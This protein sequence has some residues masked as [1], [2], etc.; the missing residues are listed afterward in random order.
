[1]F[2]QGIAKTLFKE[3][4]DKSPWNHLRKNEEFRWPYLESLFRQKR[5]SYFEFS[6]IQKIFSACE[7]S[8][9]VAL[10]VCHLALAAREGHL[11]IE[12][13]AK[14]IHPSVEQLWTNEEGHS[15][16]PIETEHLIHLLLIGAKHL[17]AEITVGLLDDRDN[18]PQ[19]MIC[20]NDIRYY[21]QK[22][23]KFETDFLNNLEKHVKSI[24]TP[25]INTV[26]L[27]QIVKQ[28]KEDRIL[29]E[30]QAQAVLEGCTSAL[31]LVTG[32]PGTGKTYT[33]GHLIKVFWE[34]LDEDQKKKCQIVLAAPTGKAAAN[35]QKSLSK[36]VGEME[37]AFP[38]QARTLHSL[39][40][41]R[42]SGGNYKKTRLTAD[43]V[44][45]DESSMIDIK[46]MALLFDSI[47]SGSRLILL[48]DKDQLPAVEAGSVFNDLVLSRNVENRL[49]FPI[50]SLTTCMRAELKSLIDFAQIINHGDGRE[51]LEFLK[52]ENGKGIFRFSVLEDSRDF[53]S[54]FLNEVLPYFKATI[55]PALEPAL[56][57]EFFQT[58]RILSPMR[59]GHFGV[60]TI[61]Q[62]IYEKLVRKGVVGH[63][64][65][66]PIMITVNDYR[67]DLFNGETG[68]LMRRYPFKNVG[69]EDCAFFLSRKEGGEIRKIPLLM[70]PRHE[71]A[72][73]LSVHKSQGSEYERAIIVLPEGS[74]V[75]GREVFYTAVTRARKYVEIYG[76]DEVI[77]KTVNQRGVRLSGIGSRLKKRAATSHAEEI[78]K[79]EVES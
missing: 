28:L 51:L 26:K 64:M 61:N 56:I 48:G 79:K 46:L 35:L 20:Q 7:V 71:L 21:F 1:M 13:D 6:L 50:I 77:L 74:E 14:T 16:S 2:R 42:H 70:L 52:C 72:Y 27:R 65:A 24:P 57:L 32:G 49:N 76:K 47:K 37:S 55:G 9:S 25:V 54:R 8:E 17:P 31:T 18:N 19:A 38:I 69:M 3:I 33:A 53:Q 39:L 62:L 15:L 44:I 41:I 59:K 75:F 43:L 66:I 22:Y 11:C 30:E 60:E 63:W 36:V 68:V 73:C 4:Y 34:N 40:G 45:V 10:F 67:Q 78:P 5:L 29:L 23:W 12:A 58:I